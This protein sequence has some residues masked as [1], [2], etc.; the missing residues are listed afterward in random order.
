MR[1][2]RLNR[3]VELYRR[4]AAQDATSGEDVGD[5]RPV[6]AV[7]AEAKP[8]GGAEAFRYVP[9]TCWERTAHIH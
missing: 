7:W 6:A 2:G 5:W 1:A 8:V 9:G 4:A 3:R